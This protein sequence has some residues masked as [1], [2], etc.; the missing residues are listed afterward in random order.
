MKQALLFL[1]FLS[2]TFTHSQV[3]YGAG[4]GLHF[5]QMNLYQFQGS[6]DK[7]YWSDK[8]MPEQ[9]LHFFVEPFKSKPANK[10]QFGISGSYF[11]N[12]YRTVSSDAANGGTSGGWAK[13]WTTTEK[14]QF[15]NT[16]IA[17]TFS[18]LHA[19][20]KKDNAK[21]EMGMNIYQSF[22]LTQQFNRQE[23][24]TVSTYKTVIP[25]STTSYIDTDSIV[26][27]GSPHNY[28]SL[29][30][31]LG[32]RFGKNFSSAFHFN[33]SANFNV[34]K[35]IGKDQYG[36]FSNTRIAFSLSLLVKYTYCIGEFKRK[37]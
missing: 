12:G 37:K 34:Y 2:A 22:S 11:S 13:I 33:P 7:Q 19:F 35:T 6:H 15:S 31:P 28:F 4:Y 3:K 26:I 23:T 10:I 14:A 30:L 20:G 25:S 9:Q 18:Y 16:R 1:F 24:S 27:P 17:I 29:I 5:F 36:T 21:F 8:L 32:M